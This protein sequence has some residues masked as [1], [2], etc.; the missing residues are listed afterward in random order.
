MWSPP[1]FVDLKDAAD[2]EQ[3]LSRALKL[4][5]DLKDPSR[6]TLEANVLTWRARARTLL[7]EKDLSKNDLTLTDAQRA[8]SLLPAQPA[9]PE[10]KHD[11]ALA[12]LYLARAHFFRASLASRP[13][14][15]KGW[16][17]RIMWTRRRRKDLA[18]VQQHAGEALRLD[19]GNRHIHIQ[20]SWLFENA[21]Q[22]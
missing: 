1:N 8:I 21:D 20:G 15:V 7:A 18:E 11:L 3:V 10:T 14:V 22:G 13:T 16:L 2:A 9:K 6:P 5:S 19:P 12:H 4:L 17:S